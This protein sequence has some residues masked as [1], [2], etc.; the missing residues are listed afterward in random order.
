[1]NN[2]LLN[3][4]EQASKFINKLRQKSGGITDED[5]DFLIKNEKFDIIATLA[6]TRRKL[7]A[8]TKA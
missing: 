5:R 7:G 3:R 4:R 8:A 1:M 6:T 2:K